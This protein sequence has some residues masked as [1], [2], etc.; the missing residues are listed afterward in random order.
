MV[1]CLLAVAVIAAGCSS[2]AS[3][4]AAPSASAESVGGL[5]VY[6]EENA[7]F[8]LI[9]PSGQRVLVDVWD[10]TA[11][12]AP[13]SAADVLLTTHLH[14]D[15][16]NEGFEEAF[17]GQKLTNEAGTIDLDQVKIVGL[18]SSHD[19][20]PI[21]PG[22][23]SDHIVIVDIGGFRV[24]HFGDIGQP[25]LS[26]EQIAAIGEVD[27]AILPLRDVAGV[28]GDVGGASGYPLD[29][30]AQVKP[31]LV[32]PTHTNTE[33]VTAAA[34]R[35]DATYTTHTSVTIPRDEVPGQTTLLFMGILA[36]SFGSL[37]D[38]AE[39]DW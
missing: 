38:L 18:D 27:V 37:F 33:L 2:T 6:Y 22:D 39:T 15:H 5:T 1:I 13:A 10:P 16:Y 21:V 17:P 29:L 23:A 9:G 4:T 28:G 7:Q 26:D 8:E 25:V 3:S 14:T 32:I 12:S 20:T 24:V 31:A 36:P 11:L 35:W 34:E 19:A 30:V